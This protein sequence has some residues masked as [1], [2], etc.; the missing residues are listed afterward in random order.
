MASRLHHWRAHAI[1]FNV[2]ALLTMLLSGCRLGSPLSSSALTLVS[3]TA[4]TSYTT[5]ISAIVNLGLR[6]TAPCE[7]SVIVP[8]GATARWTRWESL[9]EQSSFDGGAPKS[10]WVTST[11]LAPGDWLDRLQS[12]AMVTSLTQSV[13]MS[14]GGYQADATPVAG[15]PYFLT[16]A[17]LGAYARVTVGQGGDAEHVLSYGQA[18]ARLNDLGLRLAAPCR[19]RRLAASSSSALD[20]TPVGQQQQYVATRQIVVA[21][22][23]DASNLWQTQA[24]GI[25]AGTVVETPYQPTC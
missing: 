12:L 4:S 22:T 23:T 3:F 25:A 8:V 20:W 18:L 17:E 16:S 24:R 2:L 14:C 7:N 21:P 10:L 6:H 13:N 9:D 5:A 15:T 1:V 11:I 19:E